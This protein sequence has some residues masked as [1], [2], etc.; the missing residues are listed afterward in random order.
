VGNN[1][2]YRSFALH[3]N[4]DRILSQNK[5]SYWGQNSSPHILHSKMSQYKHIL[6]RKCTTVVNKNWKYLLYSLQLLPETRDKCSIQQQFLPQYKYLY[7]YLNL[8]FEKNCVADVVS[9]HLSKKLTEG[10]RLVRVSF[11]SGGVGKSRAPNRF[12]D[13]ATERYF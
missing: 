12:Y 2:P 10:L 4:R 11:N 5:K 6:Y 8:P 7:L 9:A 3:W 1:T 13:N